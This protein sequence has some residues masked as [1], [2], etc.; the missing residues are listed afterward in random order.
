MADD[1]LAANSLEWNLPVVRYANGVRGG[2]S[3]VDCLYIGRVKRC[4]CV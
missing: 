1:D 4:K 3:V 2:L